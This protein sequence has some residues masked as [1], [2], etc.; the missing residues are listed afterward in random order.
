MKPACGASPTPAPFIPNTFLSLLLLVML[1]LLLVVVSH[2][3]VHVRAVNICPAAPDTS[4]LQ[5]RYV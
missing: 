4:A 3:V 2:M 1:L 5:L